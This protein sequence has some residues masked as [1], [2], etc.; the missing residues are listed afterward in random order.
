MTDIFEINKHIFEEEPEKDDD[1]IKDDW[2][3]NHKFGK[4]K[5][6][7]F[8]TYGKSGL[9]LDTLNPFIPITQLLRQTLDKAANKWLVWFGNKFL[10]IG[11]I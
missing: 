11:W 5:V 3:D 8:S 1:I 2:N 7:V 6:M 9:M 4:L 10:Q